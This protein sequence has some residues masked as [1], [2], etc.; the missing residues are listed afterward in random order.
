MSFQIPKGIRIF[1]EKYR[2]IQ[3]NKQYLRV[4]TELIL[5][6][7]APSQVLVLTRIKTDRVEAEPAEQYSDFDGV[8]IVFREFDPGSG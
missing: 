1:S 7:F 2:T 4:Q 3:T 8:K 5:K 6:G